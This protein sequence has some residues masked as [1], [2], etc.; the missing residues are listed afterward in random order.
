MKQ[1]VENMN[2]SMDI[3]SVTTRPAELRCFEALRQR[4]YTDPLLEIIFHIAQKL[5][6]MTVYF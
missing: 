4:R 1:M 3:I 5:R 2:I 6:R